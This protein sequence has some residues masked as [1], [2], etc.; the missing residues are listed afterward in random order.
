MVTASTQPALVL[1]RVTVAYGSRVACDSVSFGVAAGSIYA[2]L[3]RSEAGKSSLL[4]AVA[5][6]RKPSQGRVLF[7]GMDTWSGRRRVR[8]FLCSVTPSS[9][10]TPDEILSRALSREPRLLLLDDFDFG[11]DPIRRLALCRR[12]RDAAAS[13]M[14][15]V[16]ATSG[17]R[18]AEGLADRIGIL[19]AGGLALDEA[20]DALAGRFRKIRYRNEV[21]GTRTEYGTE[22][23]L[24]DAVR[25]RVRG[26]GVEAVVSNFS[27]DLFDRLRL[28]DGVVD[29]EASPLSLEEV[30]EAVSPNPPA[31]SGKAPPRRAPTKWGWGRK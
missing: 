6:G 22:L 31:A 2:L 8:P 29:A 25:V 11:G 3:G 19:R 10:S 28:T 27:A 23:D 21:T 26:S 1:D 15:L 12:L 14:T 16:L 5:G 17:A 9:R 7:E 20:A 4:A 18:D 13:G 24:F 30:F